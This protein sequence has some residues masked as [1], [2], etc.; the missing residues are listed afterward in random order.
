MLF[1][2]MPAGAG[3]A[4][5]PGEQT[6]E[7][8]RRKEQGV[9]EENNATAGDAGSNRSSV[10]L[11]IYTQSL[12]REAILSG[13]ANNL[14]RQLHLWIEKM[15]Q[16]LHYADTGVETLNNIVD[17]A[18]GNL[19]STAGLQAAP[20]GHMASPAIPASSLKLFWEL[21]RTPEFQQFFGRLVAQL[22]Q[23]PK[24]VGSG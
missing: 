3:P 17:V 8:D 19:A 9:L 13:S 20:E 14:C 1:L 4:E 22:L 21:I 2:T 10:T 11:A 23:P 12:L 18:R 24:I 15:R 5:D 16:F 6:P 7:E